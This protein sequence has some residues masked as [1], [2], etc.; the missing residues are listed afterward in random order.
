MKKAP[1]GGV[2]SI[3]Y[4]NVFLKYWPTSTFRLFNPH[5]PLPLPL[6]NAAITFL[7][8]L[9]S[10]DINIE[11]ILQFCFKLDTDNPENPDNG[12]RLFLAISGGIIKIN[13]DCRQDQW[14]AV[15]NAGDGKISYSENFNFDMNRLLC[16]FICTLV[17]RRAH[18][19]HDI[20]EIV[21]REKLLSDSDDYGLYDITDATFERQ[22]FRLNDTY[23]LYNIFFDTSIG[24]ANDQVPR[25]IQIIQSIRPS[26]KIFMR[27]DENLAV[28]YSQNVSTASWDSQ[29]WR[30]ITLNF[31]N[32]SRQL[33]GG[34]EVV[35]HFDPET[36]H[37][38][39][40]Y[41]TK[42]RD[43]NGVEFYGLN[44]EQLWNPEIFMK[45]EDI[46]ITNYIHGTYYPSRETFSHI[47]FSA[48]QY[49]KDIFIGKYDDA[50]MQTG[51]PIDKHTD[52][53][54]EHYKVWC[55]KGDGLSIEVWAGLVCA[56][57][58][59]PFRSIFMETIG[60]SYTE[61]DG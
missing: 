51:I 61:G 58:D 5:H 16:A 55:V 23:F 22:G 42:E 40:V 32:I 49:R 11:E 25:T 35:V 2:F 18:C 1:H 12:N 26:V 14:D 44:V 36:S 3:G 33:A 21:S 43:N 48:N 13:S 50:V 27:C 10:T 60:G 39:L 29:K 6:Q 30:G 54:V 7:A 57:L 53:R 9:K 37:K 41:I 17:E 8:V 45:N 31:D 20:K 24:D 56:T 34:K 15:S 19:I 38:I 46:I 52:T 59:T 28:P 4:P 47:D